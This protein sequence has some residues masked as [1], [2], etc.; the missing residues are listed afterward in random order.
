MIIAENISSPLSIDDTNLDWQIDWNFIPM[1]GEG[2]FGIQVLF[3]NQIDG[4]QT[5]KN[6]RI[7]YAPFILQSEDQSLTVALLKQEFFNAFPQLAK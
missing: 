3:W 2:K 5:N 1:F 4:E 7:L 6:H